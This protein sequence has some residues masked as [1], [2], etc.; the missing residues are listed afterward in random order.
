[1]AEVLVEGVDYTIDP[2]TGY[3]VFT[4]AYHLK[5]GSCCGSGCRNCPYEGDAKKTKK[6]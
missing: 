3:L 1:M 5:R 4:G 6:G 2:A